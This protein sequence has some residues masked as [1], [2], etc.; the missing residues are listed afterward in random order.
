M[1]YFILFFLVYISCADQGR[2]LPASTGENSEVIFVA[3]DVLWESCL[4]TLVKSTFGAPIQGVNQKESLFRVF[5]VNHKE[6]KS[7]LKTNT[8]IIIVIESPSPSV[9]TKDKWASGQF[10][11]QLKWDKN[12]EDFFEDLIVLR[13]LFLL[14]ELKSIR[15]ELKKSSIIDAEKRLLNNF[16]VKCIIPKEYQI[17]KNDSS[18]FWANYNPLNSDEIKNLL[19]FSFVPKTQNLTSEIFQRTDSV[20]AKYLRGEKPGSYVQIEKEYPPYYHNNIYRGLWRLENGFMGGPFIIKTY[21]Q[22][23]KVVVNI[24]LVFAPQNQKR[25]YIKEFEAIL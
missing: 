18:L 9:S 16:G 23:N 10:V 5:Q 14:K 25:K 19:T 17:I 20:F 13:D 4:D 15:K 12:S 6:F 22:K 21:L 8:N 1:K 2:T 7:I 3:N 11:A 24:G